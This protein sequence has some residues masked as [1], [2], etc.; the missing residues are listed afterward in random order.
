MHNRAKC[1]RSVL[2]PVEKLF[3][4]SKVLDGDCWVVAHVVTYHLCHKDMYGIGLSKIY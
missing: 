3:S 1:H 2:E 4:Q